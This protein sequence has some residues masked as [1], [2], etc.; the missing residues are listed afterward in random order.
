[1]IYRKISD[2]K[3]HYDVGIY[4]WWCHENF[5]GCLTYFALEKALKKRGYSVLMI[6]EAKGLPGRYIIPETCISMSFARENY[7]CSPQVDVKDLDKFNDICDSFIIGG[8]Q[9]WNNYIQFVKEDCFLNFVDENKTK[10][11]YSSSFGTAKHNPPKAFIDIAKPLLKRFDHIFVREDYAVGLAKKI[12]DVDATQ[13]IDAVFL[14]D[15]KDYIEVAQDIDFIFPTKFLF[16]FILNPTV[17]KRRQIE[18]IAEKLKLEVICCPDA[19]SAFHKDFEAIFSGMKILKP[20]SVS[21]FIQAYNNAHYI[22]TDSFHGMCMSFIF[23]KSFNVYYNEQRGADR[24]ISLMKTLGLQTRRILENDSVD[25]IKHK[26]NIGFNIDWN[27]AEA[28]IEKIKRESLLLLDNALLKRRKEDIRFPS[29]YN[30]FTDLISIE[31]LH[32]NR[33]FKN[34]RIL[35]TLLRDYGIKHVVLSP[36]GRDVP[37]IRMFENNADQFILH[38]VTDERSAAYYAMGIATQLRQPVVCVCTSGTAASNFL[39][40]VT[41]AYY[42]G[43]PLILVTADRYAVYLNHGEDQTIPQKHI[44]SDV[45]KMEVSLPESDG[46]RSDYQARRDVAS[47]ILESTHNGFGPVHINVPVDNISIGADI[48]RNYWSLLPYIYPH[49]L[50]ASFNNGQTDMKRW[51]DSLRKSNKILIVY[52]QNVMPDERQKNNIQKFASKY[53]CVIVTDPISNLHGKYT[54]MPHNMLQSISQD[55]FNNELS[56]DILITVGGKRLM[57]DPLTFKVR[58]GPGNIRHWQVTPDGKIKDFYFR[59]TSVIESTEDYFFEWFADNAGDI[60]NN[61]VFYEKWR[62]LNEKYSSPEITRFNSLYIQSKFLPAIPGGSILHLGV[63][64]S[65]IECRR[66]K[67][68]DSVEVYCN[69]GTNGIDG[70]TSTFMGQCAVVDN[71]LCF[72]LVGDLSFFYD[73]NS[74]WNKPLKKNMRI[75]LVNNN[76]TGLLRGHN[77]SAVSSVHNTSA[78]GWVRSTGFD[79]ISAHTKEEY[80]QKLKYFLSNEPEKALFFEVFC[81]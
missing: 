21:N 42:T 40:A 5:G 64:Q 63:G 60:V 10:L 73:M 51:V 39:P 6:Q 16:A 52:G 23:R 79:Y 50:R 27:I 45:V 29:M 62:A 19:A 28:N 9:V 41:E 3:S 37:L 34:I 44:Y 36:G 67:I 66:F 71:K 1:M 17:E 68:D 56:P 26:D 61:G 49:I 15:K 65:F 7:D 72:L 8:D 76:G 43:I 46:W 75:L 11:S 69:M 14:L 4:G 32:N 18:A 59:L 13:V 47:C 22:V 24:F 25:S 80:E 74:I 31:K 33:D 55:T 77:L 58:S 70:C 2:I 57:N 78:E 81:E 53:N 38:R 48:P 20:L 35:A 54:L 30:T 12:Y